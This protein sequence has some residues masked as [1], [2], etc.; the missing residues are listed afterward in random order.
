MRSSHHRPR[1]DEPTRAFYA[2][3]AG[4]QLPFFLV[5]I[6]RDADR[7]PG[8]RFRIEAA[9]PGARRFERQDQKKENPPGGLSASPPI[10]FAANRRSRKSSPPV[11]SSGN[12]I[13]MCEKRRPGPSCPCPH[14]VNAPLPVPQPSLDRPRPPSQSQRTVRRY[15][16]PPTSSMKACTTRDMPSSG[17]KV[18]QTAPPVA[19][20]RVSP[21]I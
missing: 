11:V 3:K 20:V 7:Q 4:L 16:S 21:S 19:L 6:S 5:E 13:H 14:S 18:S 2:C 1:R 17:V 15:R 10:P 8:R 12:V 9:G